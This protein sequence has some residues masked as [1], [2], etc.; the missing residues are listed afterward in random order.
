MS[1]PS[2][3]PSPS[4]HA[5]A[6]VFQTQWRTYEYKSTKEDLSSDFDHD[7]AQRGR[8]KRRKEEHSRENN[9]INLAHERH[10]LRDGRGVRAEVDHREA[11]GGA[12]RLRRLR[13]ELQ[14]C[15]VHAPVRGGD[16]GDEARDGG[17]RIGRGV[18]R[19]ERRGEGH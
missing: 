8:E 13:D 4:T 15:R 6:S 11:D 16:G 18:V 5:S 9:D 2:S 12:E 14:R 7:N 17:G 3:A 19:E 1:A 10:R